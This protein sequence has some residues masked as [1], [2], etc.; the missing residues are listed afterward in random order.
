MTLVSKTLRNY[1][2][3]I[4]CDER[5]NIVKIF[6]RLF[7][8]VYF[9][10]S[11]SNNRLT[12]CSD[13]LADIWS[14][15]ERYSDC[16]C[17]IAGDFNTVMSS[18]DAV[19]LRL[20]DFVN[21]CSL[22]RCDDLFPSQKVAT[23]VNLSLDQCSHIDYILV[24]NVGD[25]NCFRVLD[26]D[27]NFSDHLPLFV[28]LSFS[29]SSRPDLA[30]RPECKAK[31]LK[32]PQL[33]WDKADVRSYYS[34]TGD[35]LQPMGAFLENLSKEYQDGSVST[36]NVHCCIE[37]TYR[38]IVSVLYSAA[39]VFVP[40]CSKGFFKFWWDEELSLL[41]EAS[42]ESNRIWKAAG[43]PRQGPIFS[44]RQ[45]C[46]LQYRKRLRENQ[47][48]DTEAYTNDLH[49]ALMTKN[50]TDF[51]KCWKSKFEVK[52]K[53]SQVEG[54]VDPS[55]IADK[56][57]NHYNGTFSCNDPHKAES[58]KRDFTALRANYN[59]LPL[60]E[61][62]YFDVE[63]VSKTIA[64][65]KKGKAADMEG[66]SAEHLQ[67][68]HPCLPVL[69]AKLFQL[70]IF[71]SYIPEGFRY[72]Y[73]VPIPK[74][75]ECYSKPLTCDDFRGIAISPIL[76]KVF[77]YCIL[78][79]FGSFFDTADNQFGF[80]KGLGCSFAIRLVRN[81]V[82]NLTKG[83]STSNLCAIDLSKAFD[84]VNHHALYLKLM[85]KLVPNELLN[86]LECWLSRCYSCVKWYDA[87]SYPFIVNFGV[88]QGSVLS[89]FLF[90]IYVDDLTR[91][92]LLTRGMFIVLYADDILL[93]APSVCMLDKLLKIC[94]HELDLLD[95]AINVKKS[96]C[97]RIGPRNDSFCSP[98]S[99]SK[100]TVL[101]WV[102]EIRYLGIYIKQ[103]VNFKCS[104]DHA[105]RS[106][107]RSANAIFGRVGRVASENTTLQLIYT[108]CI[109]VLLYG[110]EACPL[111]KS[112]LS[113]LD[114]II[115]RLFMKLFKTSNI[116]VVKCCQDHFGF[117]L[118]SVIWY[119]R[120]KIFEAKFHACNNLL[121]KLT[122]C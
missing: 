21:S 38:S 60:T 99:T 39:N 101:P 73:I 7:I 80:K 93:I 66:I 104:I 61:A 54:C 78:D 90:A 77:E 17:V 118:P 56:F 111:L 57:A 53:C 18:N 24:S 43:K 98:I 28:E 50:N 4:H 69:L 62:Q 72:N 23:Y 107:Y 74:P 119:K 5:F 103:S 44:R 11:G 100:G 49:E 25:V 109:P 6:D 63:L 64:N 116:D 120:V 42:V 81:V 87:W 55:V 68:C 3:T 75:K 84:K 19:A 9:P 52:N 22:V 65:L 51:W 92:P 71:S 108:K 113:S 58:L 112:D 46:R 83:G 114:F 34:Y 10:C 79:R 15:R 26:P 1:T 8:N 36:E 40:K 67:F 59:G 45:A 102:S 96:C 110:L 76:S 106:F 47:K 48:M 33:R 32:Q 27:V 14:W 37:S 12:T 2:S 82:E 117:D 30:D 86:I 115:N 105:K 41:K 20:N 70:M 95:M 121:C 94:E 122:H 88:R 97:L 16:E 89:P 35:Y 85:K 29:G 13:L 91:S 31:I